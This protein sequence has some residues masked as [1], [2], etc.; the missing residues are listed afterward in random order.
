MTAY[1][2]PPSRL[3]SEPRIYLVTGA[4]GFIGMHTTAPVGA[5]DQVV[6][7]D[8]LNDQRM[9]RAG[10]QTV[11]RQYCIQVT[12]PTLSRLLVEAASKW[13]CLAVERPGLPFFQQSF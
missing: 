8:N 1:N 3:P 10:R 9:G 4:A 12:G 13:V 6:G 7:V 2:N 11:E 5:G